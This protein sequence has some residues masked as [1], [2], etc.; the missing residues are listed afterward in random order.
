M[1]DDELFASLIK[2]LKGTII[3][4][5][6]QDTAKATLGRAL[7]Q[8]ENEERK[9][10]RQINNQLFE[11]GPFAVTVQKEYDNHRCIIPLGSSLMRKIE[12]ECGEGS[13]VQFGDDK[14]VMKAVVEKMTWNSLIALDS[15]KRVSSGTHSIRFIYTPKKNQEVLDYLDAK[16]LFPPILLPATASNQLLDYTHSDKINSIQNRAIVRALHPTGERNIPFMIRGPPGTG[17]TTTLVELLLQIILEPQQHLIIVCT[18]SNRAADNV[19]ERIPVGYA[20]VLRF[21]SC[22][23]ELKLKNKKGVKGINYDTTFSV[24]Y[25]IIVCTIG[26]LQQLYTKGIPDIKPSHIIID[27]ASMVADTDMIMVL[28]LLTEDTTFVMFGDEK[29]LGPVIKPDALR[30]SYLATSMFERLLKDKLVEWRSS[31]CLLENYRSAP[32]IVAPFNNLFYNGELI[33]KVN[34]I[35]CR[36]ICTSFDI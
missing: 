24:K 31:V 34:K 11:K 20:K 29:Q 4:E 2:R 5:Y 13:V 33:A 22:S 3:T 9:I 23:E 36:I 8:I 1:D 7:D 14:P 12:R 25:D 17:K 28:G 30:N 16:K 27:E 10:L 18:P 26:M 35:S 6:S 32:G 15:K 21:H 19:I